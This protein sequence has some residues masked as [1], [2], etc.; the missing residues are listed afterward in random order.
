MGKPPP[1]NQAGASSPRPHLPGE[2]GPG[3]QGENVTRSLGAGL[4]AESH[5]ERA[6][7]IWGREGTWGGGPVRGDKVSGRGLST[8]TP[9]G[10]QG[11][12]ELSRSS[13]HP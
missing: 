1:P 12:R 6:V 8:P 11:S 5:K 13:V 2:L 7:I 10:P 9:P 3:R 4:G